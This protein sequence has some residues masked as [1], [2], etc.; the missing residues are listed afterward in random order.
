[1][2]SRER[3]NHA[4]HFLKAHRWGRKISTRFRVAP[5]LGNG[6]SLSKIRF[7]ILHTPLSSR[8]IA[9]HFDSH[10]SNR[11]RSISANGSMTLVALA[12]RPRLLS[13]PNCLQVHVS[14]GPGTK[15]ADALFDYFS[16]FYKSS[17]R[18][19]INAI[20]SFDQSLSAAERSL[21]RIY[22][23]FSA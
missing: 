18:L 6:R 22:E 20:T 16:E 12:R 9:M 15:S 1:M 21:R 19:L 13:A 10:Y 7:L 14:N 2:H 17:K 23:V 4:L 3:M 11:A 8:E 5:V